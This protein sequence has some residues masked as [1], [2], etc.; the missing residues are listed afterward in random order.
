MSKGAIIIPSHNAAASLSRCLDSLATQASPHSVIVADSSDDGRTERLIGERY[1]WVRR[2]AAPNDAWWTGA[3]NLGISTARN[4]DPPDFYML[5][6]DDCIVPGGE[7]QKLVAAHFRSPESMIATVI[8]Y[9]DRVDTVFFAGRRRS[10]KTDRFFYQHKDQPRSTL[11]PGLHPADLLHGMCLLIP[12][13]IVDQIG[14]FDEQ[15]FP[16]LFADDDYVLRA[17][18]SGFKALVLNDA[19]VLND[20]SRTGLNPYDRRLGPTGLAKLFFSRRSAFQLTTRCRFLYRHRSTF[21]RFLK[22]V[23]ADYGRL[24]SAIL[25]RWIVSEERFRDIA[26]RRMQGHLR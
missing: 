2:V 3:V 17:S 9:S 22:T 14:L 25:L 15:A 12:R 6:N 11:K 4:T 13:T 19:T 23:A 20:R 16:H 8:C 24:L 18:K 5:L 21:P 7:L 26:Q 10:Q 1:P